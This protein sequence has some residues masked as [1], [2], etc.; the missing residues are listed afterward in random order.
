[1][2]ANL[3]AIT[4]LFAIVLL[5]VIWLILSNSNQ[6]STR[7]RAI[8]TRSAGSL[9]ATSDSTPSAPTSTRQSPQVSRARVRVISRDEFVDTYRCKDGSGTE[10]EFRFKEVSSSNWRIYIE[11]QPSYGS[12][13]EGMHETHRLRDGSRWYV[14]WDSPIPT[15]Q[16]AKSVAALWADKTQD[17]IRSGRRF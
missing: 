8:G 7:G 9:N 16:S 3:T 4:V 6:S 10:Y 13:A 15:A 12:R 2:P 17:Y 5:A 11:N 1:M 14:C